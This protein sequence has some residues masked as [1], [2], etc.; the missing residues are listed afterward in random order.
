MPKSRPIPPDPDPDRC[1]P[2][3]DQE[4][5]GASIRPLTHAN[6]QALLAYLNHHEQDERLLTGPARRW[7]AAGGPVVAV[8]CGPAPTPRPGGA[9]PTRS[10]AP[11]ASSSPLGGAAGR[12]CTTWPSPAAR[13]PST[14]WP[15]AL[16]GCWSSTPSST[17]G[18]SGW[19]ATGCCGMAATCSSRRCERCGGRPTR[20]MKSWRRRRRCGRDRGRPRG[21]RP[22]GTDA[23]RGGHG[24]P[25]APGARPAPGAAT[26]PR[27]RAGRMASDVVLIGHATRQSRLLDK[28]A[29]QRRTPLTWVSEEAETA[30]H[31]CGQGR[32]CGRRRH[33]GA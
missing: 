21:Q 11:P 25:S 18:G 20:P 10:G 2:S 9:A 23:G 26:D 13:P 30:W 5:Q 16:A 29:G 33:D 6:L 12:S 27:A 31:E 28:A 7:P 17:G 15:S 19:T 3:C 24:R 32:P 22:L 1:W 14:T 8:R 4:Q